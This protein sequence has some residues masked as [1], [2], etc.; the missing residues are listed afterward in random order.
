MPFDGPGLWSGSVM[1]AMLELTCASWLDI[2]V[3]GI[4]STLYIQTPSADAP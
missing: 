3:G 4:A 1:I 2:G